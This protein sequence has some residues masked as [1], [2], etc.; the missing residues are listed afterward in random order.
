VKCSHSQESYLLTCLLLLGGEEVVGQIIFILYS[1]ELFSLCLGVLR[2]IRKKQIENAVRKQAI[3]SA[4]LVVPFLHKSKRR[5]MTSN[6]DM[7]LDNR[8]VDVTS[9]T[10]YYD[11]DRILSKWGFADNHCHNCGIVNSDLNGLLMQCNKVRA[12]R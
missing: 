8:T 6:L 9:K 12:F 3:P 10:E 7:T 5:K 11:S 2:N 1:Y 4:H